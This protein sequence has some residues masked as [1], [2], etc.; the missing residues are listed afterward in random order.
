MGAR[1]FCSTSP[2]PEAAASRPGWRM[3]MPELADSTWSVAEETASA[4]PLIETPASDD[5]AI[6]S[7]PRVD[8]LSWTYSIG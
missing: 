8:G 1:R 4:K 7:C 6:K 2:G 5:V 3:R